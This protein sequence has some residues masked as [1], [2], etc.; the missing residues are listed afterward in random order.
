MEEKKGLE[1]LLVSFLFPNVINK[2]LSYPM[3]EQEDPWDIQIWSGKEKPSSDYRELSTLD[4]GTYN[5]A[6][7]FLSQIYG[8]PC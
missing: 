7:P 8:E 5:E 4:D 6:I 2:S 3:Q 1:I